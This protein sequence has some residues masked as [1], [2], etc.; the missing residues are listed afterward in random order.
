[1]S[2]YEHRNIDFEISWGSY[3]TNGNN[4]DGSEFGN[5][6]SGHLLDFQSF[7]GYDQNITENYCTSK[8][9]TSYLDPIHHQQDPSS[10]YGHIISPAQPRN[11]ES[12]FED[13][14][15]LLEELGIK[16]IQILEKTLAA[17]NPFRG[18]YPV[19]VNPFYETDL[20]G[21]ASFCVILGICLFLAGSKAHFGYVYG[22]VMIT[23]I[24]MYILISLMTTRFVT[25]GF[26]AS[27]LGYCLLPI[28]FL[29]MLGVFV[30][31][32]SY[33]GHVCAAV[34][35]IWSS[36]SASKLFVNMSA[37]NQQRPLIAY[38]CL[39]LYGTF[40]LIIVF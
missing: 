15:P 26:V 36:L 23:C 33:V 14:P 39:L 22:L 8:Q 21:P 1:M 25:F 38:P 19:E 10:S 12:E 20:A 18:D 7:E 11:A 2:G 4:F 5:A 17:L 37:D 24:V 16:P 3:N 31:L 27:V 9:E 35:V 40:A 28:V 32:H 6:N 34:A 13:E 29:S 30:S